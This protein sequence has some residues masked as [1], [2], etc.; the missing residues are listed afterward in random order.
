MT[1]WYV[2]RHRAVTD[3]EELD[4]KVLEVLA[5]LEADWALPAAEKRDD[6][7]TA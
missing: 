2:P 4:P 6:S 5:R 1:V 7:K 3:D